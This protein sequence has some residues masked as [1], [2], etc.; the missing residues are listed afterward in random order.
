MSRAESL[1]PSPAPSPTG[2]D[3]GIFIG[4]LAGGSDTGI[5]IGMLALSLRLALELAALLVSLLC[6]LLESHLSTQRPRLI[7][8][9]TLST[10][11]VVYAACVAPRAA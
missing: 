1:P 8:A 7:H 11:S 2:T 5:F 3:T 9:T 4:M 6:I 10:L